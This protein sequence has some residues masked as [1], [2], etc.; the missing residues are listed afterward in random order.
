MDGTDHRRRDDGRG[1]PAHGTGFVWDAGDHIVTNSHVIAAGRHIRVRGLAGERVPATVAAGLPDRDIA[2]LRAS[3]HDPKPQ[4]RRAA[5][6][7]TGIGQPVFARGN[8]HGRGLAM[9]AGVVRAMGRTVITGPTVQLHGMVQSTLPLQPGNSGG[10]AAAAGAR[11][12]GPTVLS[13][14]IGTY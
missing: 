1:D 8:P 9:A 14:P 11:P 3:L 10:P 6:Q 2:V 7:P 5:A 13:V 12:E 4:R